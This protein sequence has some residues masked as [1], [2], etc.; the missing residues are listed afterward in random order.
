VLWRTTGADR[1]V[2]AGMINAS[3][4]HVHDVSWSAD[5][6]MLMV[7]GTRS[8]FNSGGGL[9]LW[10]V[11]D[12]STPV[13]VPLAGFTDRL[14]NVATMSPDTTFLAISSGE[15]AQRLTVWDI[16]D[17]ARPKVVNERVGSHPAV[18]RSV[19]F[20]PRGGV[21][22]TGSN[23]QTVALWS[24]PAG[25]RLAVLDGHELAVSDVAFTPD[26][27]MVA[28]LDDS[29]VVTFWDVSAPTLPVR[30]H[31][32]PT[33]EGNPAE[34]FAVSRDGRRVVIGRAEGNVEIWDIGRI[35]DIVNDPVRVAC[36]LTGRG[37]TESE[38]RLYAPERPFRSTC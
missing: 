22:A 34:S 9:T 29:G 19:A 4:L 7:N 13:E 32:I 1:P 21:I 8:G 16:A 35:R 15:Q 30:L 31:T 11:S 5:G 38:W 26:A 37:L 33:Q 2:Q 10:D 23:D 14:H 24:L 6:S 28:V 27:T 18:I 25:E 17:P 36:T 12:L 3:G 20:S